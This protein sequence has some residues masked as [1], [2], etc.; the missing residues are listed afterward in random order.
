MLTDEGVVLARRSWGEADRILVVYAKKAG[1]LKL[2]ARGV[3]RPKSRK[4]GHIE[5]FSKIYF[6]YFEGKGI[7]E[8]VE[9]EVK[10]AYR[11]VREDLQKTSVAYFLC[12]SVGR[13]TRE[14]EGNQA[15]YEL[16][17]NN[18]AKLG[19]ER[20]LKKLRDDFTVELLVNLGFWEAGVDIGDKDKLL[21]RVA[22]R[23]FGSIRVGKKLQA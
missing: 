21:E 11:I 22:E 19:R 3:R 20:R 12:E 7:S 17:V 9:V 23:E 13:L 5:P 15:L 6:S 14:G 8:M 10:E 16:L 4:R 1:K 18:L 2:L